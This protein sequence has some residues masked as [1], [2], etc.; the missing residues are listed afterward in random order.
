MKF[1]NC[2]HP[3]EGQ[4][5]KDWKEEDWHKTP[6][7]GESDET[8]KNRAREFL[9]VL[10]EEGETINQDIPSILIVT[11]GGFIMRL[12]SIIFDEMKYCKMPPNLDAT[13]QRNT[14]YSKFMMEICKK[15]HEIKSMECQDACNSAHLENL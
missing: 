11:H 13:K 2:Q 9:K 4:S 12:F 8:V 3:Y 15:D 7:N 6:E 14:S 10:V 5:S 1:H